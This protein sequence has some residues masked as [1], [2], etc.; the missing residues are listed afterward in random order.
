MTSPTPVKP[1]ALS[2]SATAYLQDLDHAADLALHELAD[3]ELAERG[4]WLQVP[5]RFCSR[6]EPTD[7]LNSPCMVVLQRHHQQAYARVNEAR[8]TVGFTAHWYALAAIAAIRAAQDGRE[9]HAR[10]LERLTLHRPGRSRE[11]EKGTYPWAPEFRPDKADLLE[12]GNVVSRDEDLDDLVGEVLEKVAD[13]YDAAAVADAI[14]EHETNLTEGRH[15]TDWDASALHTAEQHARQ[16]P[17]LLITLA[18]ALVRVA[19]TLDRQELADGP[20]NP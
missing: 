14:Y 2:Q 6:S 17:E 19:H 8:V 1:L 20:P 11:R 13:A 12:A 3:A 16:L 18:R 10:E 15:L 4:R 9:L 7:A 5:P